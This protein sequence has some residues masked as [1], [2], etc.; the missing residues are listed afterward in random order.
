MNEQKFR[1]ELRRAESMRKADI[2]PGEHYWS[3]YARGLR[4]AYHGV[5]FGSAKEHTSLASAANDND[6]QRRSLGIGYLGG[7]AF[8]KGCGV[9]GRPRVFD[10][11]TVTVSVRIPKSISEQIPQSGSERA[12]F[13]RTALENHLSEI[14]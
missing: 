12:E 11:D 4:R 3:G 10:E 6:P 7:L 14:D 5:N 9:L 8:G 2:P 13:I 1:C